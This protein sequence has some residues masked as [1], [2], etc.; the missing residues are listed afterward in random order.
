MEWSD[1]ARIVAPFSLSGDELPDMPLVITGALDGWEARDWT[2]ERIAAQFGNLPTCVRLS[3][4]A[5]K[6][7][8]TPAVYEGECVYESATLAELCAWLTHAGGDG[9]PQHGPLAR[10]RRARYSAY[11]DYQDM[12]RLFS[13]APEAMRAVDWRALGIERDGS[14]STLWLGSRGA[15][16]PTHYDSYAAPPNHTP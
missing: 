11:A 4:F 12:A 9:N 13:G 1:V 8:H 3:P 7:A 10:Y 6:E 2:P 15:H 16:T 5:E 14:F